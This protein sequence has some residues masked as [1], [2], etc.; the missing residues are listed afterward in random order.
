MKRLLLSAV[1]PA[2]ISVCLQAQAP[3]DYNAL[4]THHTLKCGSVEREYFLYIP[5]GMPE[6]APLVVCMRGFS[7][8][9]AKR[10]GF[11]DF[12]ALAAREKFA[13]CVPLA[14]HDNTGGYGWNVGYCFQQADK[15]FSKTDDVR[16][17]TKLVRHLQKE[18]GLSKENVFCTGA[19]NGGEMCYHM[20]Y[21]KPDLFKAYA[22][23]FGLTMTWLYKSVTPR[24]AVPLIE[25]HGTEDHVS[26][27]GGDPANLGGWGEYVS[28][29]LAVS[30]WALMA[31]C[32]HESCEELVPLDPSSG[33]KV[34]L[35]KYLGGDDGIEVWLYEIVGAGHGGFGKEINSAECIW[36]FFRKYI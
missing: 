29:P 23:Q 13:V 14:L 3:V 31:R 12:K 35:H 20:A 10:S 5:E 33:R 17:L 24:K 36:E 34:F 2:V 26:E 21:V 15:E 25:I 32:T 6:G 19:S 7:R 11:D 28:V 18:Y 30:Q 22:P 9:P 8:K 16:Y 27:W 4:T 1:L